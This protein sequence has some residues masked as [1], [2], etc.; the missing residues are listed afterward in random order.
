MSTENDVTGPPVRGRALASGVTSAYAAARRTQAAAS[1][2]EALKLLRTG[3]IDAPG[4]L[5]LAA[6]DAD[7]GK[8]G[9]IRALATLGWNEAAAERALAKLGINKTRRVAWLFTNSGSRHCDEFLRLAQ[10]PGRPKLAT[11][12]FYR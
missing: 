2:N 10:G 3:Q 1:R 6:L 9:L 7:V 12:W 4:L 5:L 11:G 8:I